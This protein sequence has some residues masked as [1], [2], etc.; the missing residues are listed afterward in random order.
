MVKSYL[1]SLTT[2]ADRKSG[3][4]Q[5]SFYRP[6]SVIVSKRIANNIGY[7]DPNYVTI[8]GL[9]IGIASFFAMI[10]SYNSTTFFLSVVLWNISK[11]FDFVDGNLARYFKKK[12]YLGKFLDGYIDMLNSI[13]LV[14]GVGVYLGNLYIALSFAT[15]LMTS[16]SSMI[17]F[18][19]Y[20][21][22]NLIKKNKKKLYIKKKNKKNISFFV[23]QIIKYI[24]FF[25][26]NLT[27]PLLFVAIF[28]D[29]LNLWLVAY[30]F[31]SL[32]LSTLVIFSRI[33]ISFITLNVLR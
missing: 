25:L 14:I 1:D 2:E 8:F 28:T 19:Y 26:S 32:I 18:R 10:F 7:I 3:F 15:A 6:I 20:S 22:L 30:S 23:K 16:L 5:I 4:L 9:A 12:T 11:I 17:Y 21:F 24:E 33:Y 27:M 13:L 31:C 29:H